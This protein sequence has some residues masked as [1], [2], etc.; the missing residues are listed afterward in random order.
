MQQLY[1]TRGQSNKLIISGRV[2][3][4]IGS[5]HKAV[6]LVRISYLILVSL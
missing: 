2:N 5:H 1:N 6:K 4:D 3:F